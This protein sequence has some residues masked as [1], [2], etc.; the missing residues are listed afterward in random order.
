MCLAFRDAEE[1]LEV[2][3]QAKDAVERDREV[4]AQALRKAEWQAREADRR[5][6]DGAAALTVAE[7]VWL[8]ASQPPN[9]SP[10]SPR[11]AATP[12]LL[13]IVLLE[14]CMHTHSKPL[15]MPL[16]GLCF[17]FLEELQSNSSS[18]S[19]TEIASVTQHCLCRFTSSE[20]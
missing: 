2:T 11:A 4:A 20:A 3:G 1:E 5:A 15:H 13:S 7:Q 18:T 14:A 10:P 16:S 9:T 12:P 17:N 19:S 6:A 8:G